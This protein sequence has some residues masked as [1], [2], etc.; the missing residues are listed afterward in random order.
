MRISIE[1]NPIQTGLIFKTA[2]FEVATTVL[3]T[4]EEIQIIR[5]RGLQ[6]VKLMDRRPATAKVDDSD[7]KFALHL[8]D[9][10]NGKTDRFICATPALA[11]VYQDELVDMLQQI[12]TW[13]GDN[14]EVAPPTVTEL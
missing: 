10:L 4:H 5:Q 1:H 12:K 11:K 13:L 7:E 8:G 9:I 2:M 14:A 6:G 3:F